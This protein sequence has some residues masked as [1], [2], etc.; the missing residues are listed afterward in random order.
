MSTLPA[1]G[2]IENASRTNA[3]QKAALEAIRDIL[4]ESVGGGA[5]TE[6]T[7]SSGAIT[8]AEGSGGGI[9]RVDTEGN[10]AADTLDTIAQTNTRDGQILILMA[11]NAARVVTLNHAAGGSGQMLLE[12]DGDFVFASLDAWVAFRRDGTDWVE[13]CRHVPIED[14]TALTAPAAADLLEIWDDDVNVTKKITAAN[15]HSGALG[16]GWAVLAAGT[17]SSVA[18]LNHAQLGLFSATYHAY[19]LIIH[20][21]LPATN[22]VELHL[23]LS[24]DSGATY[25]SGASDYSHTRNISVVSGAT[26]SAAGSNADAEIVLTAGVGNSPGAGNEV[27]L[28]ITITDP[29]D[30]G[31]QTCVMWALALTGSSGNW[32]SVTGAGKY[33]PSGATDALRVL[34]SSGNIS[35]GTYV[36]YGLKAA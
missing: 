22:A 24:T 31:D 30:A 3:E 11:E 20:D 34:F 9:F 21:L 7:I 8:P 27:K 29:M 2:Y 6:L 26:P 15:L 36:L 32:A 35:T 16:A 18:A 33:N 4:A 14:L 10:A 12:N 13:L 5:R 25:K 1:A 28:E 23:Q 17:L 19:K